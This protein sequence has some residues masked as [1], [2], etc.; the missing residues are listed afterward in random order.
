[1]T[2]ATLFSQIMDETVNK[3]SH[4]LNKPDFSGIL[5]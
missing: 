1:M 4:I 3:I 5:S 2:F